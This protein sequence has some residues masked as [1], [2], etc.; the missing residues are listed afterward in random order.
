[1]PRDTSLSRAVSVDEAIDL[2]LAT[3]RPGPPRP[4]GVFDAVGQV[5]AEAPTARWPL[6]TAAVSVMDGYAV[7]RAELDHEMPLRV[8]GESAAGHPYL[9]PLPAQTAIRISTG[10]VVPPGADTVIAQEDV[11]R[12]EDQ[13][14][15]VASALADYPRGR[16]VRP[17]GSDVAVDA[18]LLPS[19]TRLGPGEAALLASAGH[20]RTPVYPRPRVNIVSTGDELRALGETPMPGDVINTNAPMLAA[21]VEDAGGS[22]QTMSIATDDAGELARAVERALDCELLITTGGL[23]VGDHDHVFATLLRLGYQPQFDAIRLR[24][25]KP[26]SFGLVGTTGVLAL[27]GNPAS[28]YVAF[29]L[30]GRPWIRRRLGLAPHLWQRPRRLVTL[31]QPTAGGGRRA[32]IVRARVHGEHAEALPDQASGALR[33]IAGHNALLVIPEGTGEV[34]AGDRFD[35][36][37][38][39]DALCPPRANVV[40]T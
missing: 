5:L 27:P 37:L 32:H 30:L 21:Q 13:I 28:S 15:I 17:A 2:V 3:A 25:G 14:R 7:Q 12:T 34:R 8:A 4:T 1:M 6:P 35:A 24:P 22:P 39:D 16:F 38:L 19:G 20:P 29:E 40:S 18:E 36:L 10:A 9:A 11:A 33:S 31:V 26:T 23:S